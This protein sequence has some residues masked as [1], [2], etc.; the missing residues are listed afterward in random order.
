MS[1]WP[2]ACR[3]V[4]EVQ[5]RPDRPRRWTLP[6]YWPRADR[7]AANWLAERDRNPGR[8][9][10]WLRL[11]RAR[12]QAVETG[13]TSVGSADIA[14]LY[15]AFDEAYRDSPK[16]AWLMFKGTLGKL[17]AIITAQG[18]PIVQWQGPEAW[19]LG[20]PVRISPSMPSI[21]AQNVPIVFGDLSYFCVRCSVDPIPACS[22]TRKRQGW[23]RR[24]FRS[25]SFRPIR[26][27][28]A[29]QRHGIAGT[30]RVF[31]EPFLIDLE[32]GI[33]LTS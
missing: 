9:L 24:E 18:L 21:G 25:A 15:Y 13:A 6:R 5:R 27:R 28:V 32:V 8:Q 10:R 29:L 12:T 23:L 2:A 7:Q 3:A 16:C 11:A 19:I 31:S 26:L 33:Q 30:D 4:Q 14:N 1:R 17:A 22:C 20:K